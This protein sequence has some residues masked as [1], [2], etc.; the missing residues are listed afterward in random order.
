MDMTNDLYE[1]FCGQCNAASNQI[2]TDE[3]RE[4][5]QKL[6]LSSFVKKIADIAMNDGLDSLLMLSKEIES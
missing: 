5:A 2:K 3:D 6:I 1:W 4:R